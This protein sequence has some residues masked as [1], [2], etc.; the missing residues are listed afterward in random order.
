MF[1]VVLFVLHQN[2][3]LHTLLPVKIKMKKWYIYSLEYSIA[4]KMH[5]SYHTAWMDLT[6]TALGQKKLEQKIIY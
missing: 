5:Y 2:Q 3:K 6:N 4:M 1:I